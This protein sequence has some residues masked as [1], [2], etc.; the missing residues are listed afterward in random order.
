MQGSRVLADEKTK[1]KPR[2]Y[3][4]IKTYPSIKTFQLEER[5]QLIISGIISAERLEKDDKIIKVLKIKEIEKVKQKR[6]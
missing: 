5:G 1:T 2:L 6:I 3:L 4:D